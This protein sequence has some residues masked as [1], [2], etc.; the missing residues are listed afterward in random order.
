M[1]FW[2]CVASLLLSPIALRLFN[3][4]QTV[5]NPLAIVALAMVVKNRRRRA[6]GMEAV[7]GGWYEA[8]L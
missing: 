6:H 1:P 4:E 2:F 7:G 8:R 5:P 3:F